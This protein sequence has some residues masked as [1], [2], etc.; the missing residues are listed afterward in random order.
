MHLPTSI[1]Q[2][3]EI[4][5]RFSAFSIML[6]TTGMLFQSPRSGKFVSDLHLKRILDQQQLVSFN[7]LDRGNLYQIFSWKVKRKFAMPMEFQSP[8]SGKFV[9]NTANNITELARENPFQSPRSGKFVSNP[10]RFFQPTIKIT[11]TCF[12]PLDRGNLYL[13]SC[14]KMATPKEV[15]FNPLDRGNLYQIWG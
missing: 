1:P 13:I 10:A 5:I 2:I 12:N 14:G 15:C 7:P 9:S 8:R 11:N 4:C 3:G 6:L